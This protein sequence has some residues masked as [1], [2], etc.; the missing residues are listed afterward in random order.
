[1]ERRPSILVTLPDLQ[2]CSSRWS[3][4][5]SSMLQSEHLVFLWTP[6]SS[7]CY[8]LELEGKLLGTIPGKGQVLSR[9]PGV[10]LGAQSNLQN[11]FHLTTQLG[12]TARYPLTFHP[13][14][15]QTHASTK[16][17]GLVGLR[18]A[19]VGCLQRCERRLHHRPGPTGFLSLVSVAIRHRARFPFHNQDLGELRSL[20]PIHRGSP[21]S[22]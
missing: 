17:F 18:H 6:A 15:L 9:V 8:C 4:C 7:N 22:G 11:P 12:A 16:Y 21:D 13:K 19:N 3:N 1:M 5:V 2:T 20:S 14:G 10:S